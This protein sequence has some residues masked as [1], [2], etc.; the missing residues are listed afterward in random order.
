[1]KKL[2][3]TKV[4]IMLAMLTVSVT[5]L[6]AQTAADLMCSRPEYAPRRERHMNCK[7][8]IGRRQGVWKSYTYYGYLLSEITYKDNKIN[9]PVTIYYGVTGKVREKSN[10]FDGKKDGDYSSYFFSGQVMAEGE[11]DYGKKIGV[12]AYYYN[13]TGET[14]M[15]GNYTS[16]KRDG[17]WKYYSSKGTLAKVVTYKMGEAINTKV[18][19]TTT[20]A[21]NVSN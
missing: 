14:R 8:F 5:S 2:L 12:W 11:F 16:G 7:D 1:M 3:Q 4:V 15:T 19:N 13:S 9:G 18:P 10:F 20:L 6:V 17:D 21:D